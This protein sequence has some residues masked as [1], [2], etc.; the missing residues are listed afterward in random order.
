MQVKDRRL[1]EEGVHV[2]GRFLMASV[3]R[4]I[5]DLLRRTCLVSQW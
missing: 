2:T 4:V 3:P 1:F 5:M